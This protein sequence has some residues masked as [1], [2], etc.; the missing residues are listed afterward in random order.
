MM[1]GF[2]RILKEDKFPITYEVRSPRGSNIDE[3]IKKI[4][5]YD[6]L[7]RIAGLNVCNNPVG[8][9]MIDPAPYAG[10][11]FKEIG[12]EPIAHLTCRDSTIGGLQRWLLGAHSLGIKTLLAMTGDYAVGDYP[13]EEKVDHI[14]SLELITGIKRYLNKGKLMPELS[15]RQSRQR[16]RYLTEVEEIESPTDFKVGGVILPSR[17]NET[18]YT[19]R[20]IEAGADFFQTQITYDSKEILDFLEDL[21]D[22]VDKH[23]PVFVGTSPF[24]SSE[25]MNFLS[26]T[27]P[28]VNIPDFVQERMS[29][30]KDFGE[31]SVKHSIEM[32]ENIKDGVQERGLHFKVGAH[33]IPIRSEEKAGEI[34]RGLRD[35]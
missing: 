8:R 24:S 17:S 33:I 4:K 19:A 15:A 30:A 28:Q 16:N 34:V 31:E 25:E 26:N 5:E 29:K 21:D 11:I 35:I 22:K 7:D 20:K 18:D 12:I 10:R 1:R 9:V 13:A 14:N 3:Y 2:E 32:Y 27:I 6:F 23:P